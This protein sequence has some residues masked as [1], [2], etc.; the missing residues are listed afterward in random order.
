MIPHSLDGIGI[1]F[2]L[3]L[4]SALKQPAR[5]H[6]GLNFRRAFKNIENTRVA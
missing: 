6:L 1:C 4:I 3:A 2:C 5:N